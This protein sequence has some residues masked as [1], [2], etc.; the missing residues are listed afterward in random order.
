MEPPSAP[1]SGRCGERQIPVTD[2]GLYTTLV[3]P[4][5]VFVAA[6]VL[7]AAMALS[8]PA[9]AQRSGKI[10]LIG[11]SMTVAT[12]ADEMCGAGKELPSC[13]D[14]KLGLHDLAWSHAGGVPSWS[15]ASRLGYTPT[16]VVNVAE[17]GAQ[18]KDAL[19]QAM[20]IGFGRRRGHRLHQPRRQ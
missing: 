6:L 9:L 7:A 17:D 4:S 12:H 3:T 19:G 16:R 2:G 8:A 20:R 10:G 1:G 13:L 18:W 11:D 5:L 15:I 14:D